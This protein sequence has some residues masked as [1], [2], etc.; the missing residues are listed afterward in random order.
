MRTDFQR[1]LSPPTQRRVGSLSRVR[2]IAIL[3]ISLTLGGIAWGQKDA[4]SIVGIVEDPSGA[5]VP[6]AQI[7]ITDA[8]RGRS[9]VTSTDAT[10]NYVAGLLKIGRY[11]VKV[12]KKDFKTAIIGPFD[13]QLGQRREINVTLQIGEML[14]KVEV[15]A[16]PDLE[17]QTSDLGQVV[18]NRTINDLPLNGRNFSQL[19]LLAAGVTPSEPGAANEDTFGF[20]SSGARSY[21]NNYLLDGIDNNSN[22]TDLQTGASYVIQPSVDAVEEFKVQTSGYSAEFGRGN[23]AVLNATIKSGTN[24]FHG[25]VFEFLRNDKF[26][27]RNFF[28]VKRGAYQRNQFGATF[29]GPVLI[30]HL[31]DGRNHSFFFIDY[32]GLRTRQERP[33]Q[34]VVPTAAMRSGDFSAFIDYTSDA[35]VTDC[36]GSPT[37]AGELF[38][39]RLT[40]KD[41]NSPTGFCGVPFG[42]DSSGNPINIIPSSLFDPLAVSLIKLWPLPNVSGNG[43]VGAINYL[44]EPKV[45]ENQNNFDFRFDHTFSEK[46]SAFTRYSYQVQPSIH[47]A[48]FQATGGGGNEG[49]AGFDHN[50]YSSVALSETHVFSPHVENE[51]RLGYNRIDARHLQFDF[52][53]NVSSQLGISGVPFGPKNGGLP[54]LDFSDVGSIGTPLSLPSIQ[55]Q[56]TYS[57]SDN[58][59]VT[60]G[61]H[62]LRAGAEIRREEFTILQPVAPRG[63]LNFGNTFT[64][65]PANPGSGGSG[66]ASFLVGLP[67]FGEMTSVHNVDYQRPVYAFYIQDN[68]K[69]TSALTLNLGLRYDLFIPIREGLN[70]QGT[71]DIG[72]QTLLVPRGQ[73]AKLTPALAK[74]IPVSATASRGLVPADV[75]NFAPRVGF[76]YKFKDRVVL[77]SSYGIFYAGYESGG[78]ANPSPGFNPPFSEAQ[79]FQMPCAA[80]TA[81]FANEQEDCSIPGF[82]HFSSGFPLDS[83]SNPSLPQLFGLDPSFRSPYMQQ[84]QLSTQYDLPF[85]TVLEIAYSGSKGT[86]LYSFYN[87]NQDRPSPNPNALTAPRRPIPAIDNAIFQLRT[88]GN[89]EYNGLQIRA[90]HR[91]SHGLSLLMTYA[92]GHSLDDSSS[93]NLQ[94]RNFSDFRWSAHPEWEH[95]NSDFDVRH[96]FVLSYMYEL[97]FGRGKRFALKGPANHVFG[98]W[99]ISGIASLISGNWFT[100]LDGNSNFANSDGSQRPDT[101][102]NP[103]G[104]PCLPGTLFNTCAFVDPPLGSFGN[105]RK[106][107]VLGPNFRNWD[108]SIFKDFVPRENTI[109]QFR[110]EFFN[111]LNHTTLSFNNVGTDL[112][113]PTFGFP[114]QARNPREVQFALKFYY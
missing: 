113:S 110:A 98:G 72:T 108:F 21:Q 11:T 82:S 3:S 50:F 103:N 109:L 75:D 62:S 59:T 53:R 8:D 111:L 71:Y 84:W 60:H 17:T 37:Y 14:Q 67:D 28:E 104:R 20:S 2:F 101:V 97:P 92:Y 81:N 107:T 26:D 54:L 45:Q 76:A 12:G 80:S 65:N 58:L 7:T 85:E 69:I 79:S 39:N 55:V 49:S 78:W 34:D 35:G 41:K 42:Y 106:N 95:G 19:A 114:D 30:P 22:I 23:G 48:V 51:A 105:T 4:A 96:R 29:G 47:P 66:F 74:I 83:L 43:G 44:T 73:N 112:A 102:A 56:N 24:D 31:Y 13:L 100:I 1:R 25:T 5:V 89:S 6:G 99:E 63:H 61:K 91:F 27:A 68:Y 10:G 15:N 77:R 86:R 9:F 32:E 93:V 57:F 94:S 87:A 33:L 18:D 64:D 38:N 40:R 90:E 46:D 52:N 70:Q 36:N 88:D 16:V